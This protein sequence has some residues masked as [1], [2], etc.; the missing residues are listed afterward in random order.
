MRLLAL[1]ILAANG[2]RHYIWG[3]RAKCTTAVRLRRLGRSCTST[4]G[5]IGFSVERV[6][7]LRPCPILIIAITCRLDCKFYIIR[8]IQILLCYL[9][10]VLRH[11]QRRCRP[12]LLRHD[13]LSRMRLA[14][15]ATAWEHS[16]RPLN[17]LLLLIPFKHAHLLA[18][19]TTRSLAL[20]PSL[21]PV[22]SI[23]L[24]SVSTIFQASGGQV[25][26]FDR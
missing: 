5:L 26:E 24:V 14:D 12:K 11:S 4:K 20:L 7:P 22:A 23:A 13:L 17:F 6:I 15:H 9:S 2:A 16:S 19:I 10:Y 1:I 25:N 21:R 18:T 3:H 8:P